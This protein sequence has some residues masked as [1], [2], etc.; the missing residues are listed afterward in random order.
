MARTFVR[1]YLSATEPA[2]WMPMGGA[3]LVQIAACA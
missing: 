2:E 3:E 1:E